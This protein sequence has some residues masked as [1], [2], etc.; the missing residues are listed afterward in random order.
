MTLMARLLIIIGIVLIS[1]G[2]I[3]EFGGKY[4]PFGRLPGDVVIDK[5]NFKFYFPISTSIVISILLTLIFWLWKF[6]SK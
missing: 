4:V 6:F 5:G 3:W 2:L 1:A